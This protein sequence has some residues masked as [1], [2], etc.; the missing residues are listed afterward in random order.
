MRYDVVTQWE[1]GATSM[2]NKPK[3]GPPVLEIQRLSD[4]VDSTMIDDFTSEL[5]PQPNARAPAIDSG[6]GYRDACNQARDQAYR[7]LLQR[8]GWIAPDPPEPEPPPT[9]GSVRLQVRYRRGPGRR[10]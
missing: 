3:P 8:T 6:Q 9:K 1:R 4:G 10:I 5:V 2:P 7:E